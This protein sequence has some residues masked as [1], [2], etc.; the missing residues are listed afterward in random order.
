[1]LCEGQPV[2]CGRLRLILFIHSAWGPW[3]GGGSCEHC[4]SRTY[5]VRLVGL[6]RSASRAESV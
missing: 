4:H 5:H 3:R 6:Q 1:M 2:S